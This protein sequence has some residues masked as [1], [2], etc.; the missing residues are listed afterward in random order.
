MAG[1][2]AFLSGRVGPATPLFVA[3][4]SFGAL[5][6]LRTAEREPAVAGAA[7]IAL[8]QSY[9]RPADAPARDI[10]RLFVFGGR[11]HI[12]EVAWGTEFVA[13]CCGPSARAVVVPT[14]DHFFWNHESD[15]AHVVLDFFCGLLPAT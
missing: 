14:A 2:L 5:M 8:P 15:V 6:A 10:P 12:T 11:D 3:G 9:V 13:G 1:A 4:Y 7:M